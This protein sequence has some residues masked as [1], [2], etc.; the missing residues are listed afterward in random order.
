MCATQLA[1]DF[2]DIFITS[3]EKCQV[4]RC[5]KTST[6]I[7]IP[8]KGK[9][10]SFNDYIPVALT[11]VIMKVFERLVMRFLKACTYD[12]LD[13]MQFKDQSRSKNMNMR[14]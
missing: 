6:I 4:P 12:N 13:P 14:L 10:S 5:F 7:P 11:S 1:L 8:K 2:T 9:V 3:L